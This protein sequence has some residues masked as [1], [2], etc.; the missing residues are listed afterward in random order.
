[1]KQGF[2]GLG[3][4]VALMLVVGAFSPVD[5]QTAS[6]TPDPFVIQLTS[7][8]TVLFSSFAG[9]MSANGRFVVVESNGDI[10]TEKTTARNNADGNREI[11]LIDYGQ[12]RVFQITNTL[13]VAKP[14][15]SPTPTPTPT[16]TPSP[17]PT[18]SPTPTP[19]PTPADP[20]NIQ[21]E[22]SNNRPM[23][24]LAPAL[25]GGVRVCTIVFSSNAPN[26]GSFDGTDTGGILAADG[27]QEIWVYQVPAVADVDLT[28]GVEAPFVNLA[29]GT[30]TRITDTAASRLP[31][32]GSATVAPF[33]AD[34]NREA[35]ISDNG[36][37]VAFVST[38][39]L[40]PATGNPDGNPEIFFFN[41]TTAAFAQ[42]TKTQDVI[43]SNGRLVFTVFNENPSIS[44]DGSVVA[45]ISNANL[46]GNNDD[47]G[48]G[49]GNGEVYV[50]NYNGSSFNNLKQ[51]TRTKTGANSATVNLFSQGRR[52]SRDGSMLALETLATDPKA[53]GSNES[54]LAVFVYDVSS[55]SFAL[56][57]SR[58][59]AS[60]GDIIHFPIFADYN[61]SLHPS[62]LVFASALNF[63]PDG[64]FPPA[65][66][67]AD[68]LNVSRVT[69]IFATQVPV[70]TSNT[71]RRLTNNP[72]GNSFGGLR[73]FT[74]ESSR[75][76]AFSLGGAELGGG[77]PDS[78]TEVFY[79]LSPA[80]ATESTESL[81]FFTGASSL[82]VP[83]P[84]A[85]PSPTPTPSPSP[86]APPVGGLAP[87]ELSIATSAT[88]LAPSNQS[89]ANGSETARRPALPVEL[90]GVAVA[91]NGAAAGLYFVGNSPSQI[92][93]VLPV[94]V[95]AGTTPARVVVN[96]NGTVVRGSVQVFA[97][98]PDIFTTT[99]GAAGR[100][101]VTNVTNPLNR[102]AEPFSVTSTDQDGSVVPTVLEIS[103]TG[104]R[105]VTASQVTVTI[106]TT[107]ITGDAILFVGP[108]LQ[109]PGFDLINVRLP[110]SLAG[111]GDV[112][113]VVTINIGGVA[114]SA[115][116]PSDTAP[117]ITISP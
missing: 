19:V 104:V 9:D 28:S 36:N 77:N 25:S 5:A 32:P 102:T 17:M 73:L 59:L 69:Q 57:G 31:T 53:N 13:N 80:V 18:P 35:T 50:A 109:A 40:V 100:A 22:I 71:F 115:S 61:L 24:S 3:A 11:F 112:P 92:N 47:D 1:M 55:D 66:N 2:C 14:A 101:I 4:F 46:T 42:L 68:G 49:N 89:S 82:P 113:I 20:A 27:N 116:R 38:R 107:A 93:F 37:T 52:L 54:F 106:G 108:N 105:A 34:D 23:I 117:H 83:S 65:A 15:P 16:P 86:S 75:R 78:S 99:M 44:A 26:P 76:L 90:N 8:P 94:G 98:Q 87:G 95:A 51:A 10:A 88:N 110:A 7:S 33:V 91:V 12:R 62:S 29:A 96:N 63:K 81:A 48:K 60:P 72:I 85:S 74:S 39:N 45:F 97:A 103:L 111:T 43:D 21:I 30:F 79:L 84:S 70:T 64:T 58:A 56:V 6:A 114:A 67:D 41:R